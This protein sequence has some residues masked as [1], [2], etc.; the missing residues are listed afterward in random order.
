MRLEKTEPKEPATDWTI[1]VLS[2]HL[3]YFIDKLS[4]EMSW[5]VISTYESIKVKAKNDAY[6]TDV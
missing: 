6:V 4:R 1:L 3:I 5:I 2:G